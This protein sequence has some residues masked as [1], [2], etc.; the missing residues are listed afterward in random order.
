MTDR[1]LKAGA[2]A[3]GSSVRRVLASVL[4]AT[5]AL[6]ALAA[7]A[8]A[9]S[10]VF[11]T[12]IG[13]FGS[14]AGQ[15]SNPRNVAVDQ[16]TGDLY[17][18]DTGNQRVVKFDSSGSFILAFGR[19]V[20]QTTGGDVCTAASGDV[21]QAGTPDVVGPG[22]LNQP[23]AVAVDNS[24]SAS[25]G[26]VYVGN[27]PFLSVGQPY[28][29]KF[30]GGGSF[31][32][33]I[34]GT[35][36]INGW[37][38]AQLGS[39]AVDPHGNLW[40]RNDFL[41]EFDSNGTFLQ[42]FQS[43]SGNSFLEADTGGGGLAVTDAHVFNVQ[44]RAGAGGFLARYTTSGHF[45]G[46][47]D[48]NSRGLALDPVTEDLYATPDSGTSIRHYNASCHPVSTPLVDAI[49][50]GGCDPDDVFGSGDL[51][52]AVGLA[53]DN[54]TQT[55][56]AADAGANQIKV[57]VPPP[58]GPPVIRSQWASTVGSTSATLNAAINAMR[59]DT[60]CRLQYVDDPAFQAQGFTSATTV[61]CD[62]A[63]LGSRFADVPVK[64][65]L[66]GLA[67]GTVYRYRFVAS[68]AAG[69]ETGAA[70]SFSTEV[71]EPNLPDDRAYEQVSPVDKD[72]NGLTQADPNVG[73]SYRAAADGHAIA[74]LSF[75]PIPGSAGPGENV[76]SS[77]TG[78]G[79]T[80]VLPTPPQSQGTTLCTFAL[81][82]DPTS[83]DF[84]K[85]VVAQ[86]INQQLGC[87]KDDPELVPGE[88]EGVANLFL[89]ENAGVSYQLI[90]R[91]PV[92]GPPA[93]AI[94]RASDPTFS[95]VVFDEQAQLTADAPAGA[96][97][98]Y[99]FANGALTL[100]SVAPDGTPL[101]GGG[102]IGGVE[103][104]R[105]AVSDDGSTIFFAGADGN[106]Y[107]RRNGVTTVQVDAAE[108][109]GPGGSGRFAFATPDGSRVFFTAPASSGLTN[110]TVA[111]SGD[112]LYRYDFSGIGTGTLT[113][114]TSSA[115][116]SVLGFTGAG[117]SG[118]DVYFV[119]QGALAA[120]ATAGEPNVYVSHN[121]VLS[122][123]AT[124]A[125][126]DA[127][128]ALF[129]PDACAW[130]S[131]P[132]ARVTPDGQHFAFNSNRPQT[133]DAGSSTFTQVY[134]Y[135]RPGDHLVCVSCPPS[136]AAPDA[137]AIIQQAPFLGENQVFVLSRELSDDGSRLF[138]TADGPLVAR[139]GNGLPDVYEYENGKPHLISSGTSTRQTRF[140]D[141]SANGDDVFIETTQ[142]LTST[143]I[144]GALDIYDVRVGGGF[145]EAPPAAPC[146]GDSCRGPL[147]GP[148]AL[149]SAGSVTFAGPGN[150][151]PTETGPTTTG[152]VTV[153]RK[154]VSGSRFVLTVKVP[155]K[156]VIS[157][158]GAN[159]KSA[160]RSAA[161]AGTYKVTVTLSAAGKR[162][163]KRKRHLS[164][165]A[166][167]GYVPATGI[168]SSATVSV[169][170]KSGGQR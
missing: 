6:L 152:K 70:R 161:R 144:D 141:A 109:A 101:P 61:A 130:K 26:D 142:R 67:P 60:T 77:R 163:L 4:V 78:S 111:G 153:T 55:L 39:V 155:T 69:D 32:S 54:Q 50:K 125:V 98:L 2:G 3:S 33:S 37:N 13:S 120:G 91:N 72:G 147:G 40:V 58:A 107:A 15:L 42:E 133:V 30:S 145:A 5:A 157:I 59:T 102:T 19:G 88:P 29:S 114:L 27:Q 1:E 11:S 132:C 158:T 25:A 83:D 139:D 148:P 35:N 68:S 8:S 104:A 52:A 44:G 117:D 137:S 121:G 162:A 160:R 150:A 128:P 45:D 96:D 134:L 115:D 7:P 80:S 146:T 31:I 100:V 164:L 43:G 119:A 21:C 41:F 76:I 73:N 143:D 74:Y 28:V 122:L 34:R 18:A 86:G 14:G 169:T 151:G 126:D 48:P 108:G 124:L 149:P 131:S 85:S 64:V 94:F 92:T 99:Q 135:D 105:H 118:D 129:Y 165:K 10:P 93:D 166:R 123:I 71:P 136:G 65:R 12:S 90:S 57:F 82:L 89:R 113:D 79:W 51:V 62:P 23:V 167:V 116:A 47:Y 20:D 140:V 97:N 56:Y 24:T 9:V 154:V 159:I 49:N 38:G 53:L 63:D 17:V 103:S 36:V 168:P 16:S 22:G 112:N 46:F 127:S 66:S 106:L 170:V 87:G 75:N 110:D 95:H 84:S 138:F 156:G 81:A